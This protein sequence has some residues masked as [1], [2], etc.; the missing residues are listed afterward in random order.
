M[1]R[2]IFY[3]L[4]AIFEEKSL[5]LL[6]GILQNIKVKNGSNRSIFRKNVFFCKQVLDFQR[7]SRTFMLHIAFMKF[8]QNHCSLLWR[9]LFLSKLFLLATV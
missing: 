5:H 9:F 3:T 6:E 4:F 1:K 8:C 7:P 2:R